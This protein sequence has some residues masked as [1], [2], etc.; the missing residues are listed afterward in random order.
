MKSREVN[1]DPLARVYRGLEL[2]AFGRDLERARFCHLDQLKTCRSILILGEGDGRFVSRL[3]R[4]AP[5][6]AILC[7]DSSAAMIAKAEARLAQLPTPR[8]KVKFQHA[9][10]LTQR[11][12][13]AEFDAVVTLFFLDCFSNEDA[14]TLVTRI[15]EALQPAATW[16]F[17]DFA[18][19]DR[20]FGR[21]RAKLWLNVLYPFFNWSTGLRTRVLPL[22]EPMIRGAG[23]S[24][25]AERTL[26]AGLLRSVAFRR[27]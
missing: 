7:V 9:D 18:M 23:F 1:F 25:V 20:G 12:G 13:V 17:A 2:V 8:G 27:V 22:V 6:A 3:V 16:L 24:P 5:S 19:P 4:L 14:R 15:S 21:V 26:Q 11:F 10:A